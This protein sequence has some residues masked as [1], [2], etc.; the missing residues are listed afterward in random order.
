MAE[1]TREGDRKVKI[2]KKRVE[3]IVNHLRNEKEPDTLQRDK[4]PREEEGKDGNGKCLKEDKEEE[5]KTK[6]NWED[7]W[8]AARKRTSSLTKPPKNQPV[9]KNI[10][11]PK[12]KNTALKKKVEKSGKKETEMGQVSVKDYIR[13][14]EEETR[15][16]KL[17]GNPGEGAGGQ[18]GR[19]ENGRDGVAGEEGRARSIRA[20]ILDTE[21]RLE[22]QQFPAEKDCYGL[23]LELGR[24]LGGQN[25][26]RGRL[27][28]SEENGFM[29]PRE[30][31]GG[32]GGRNRDY[33]GRPDL[34]E[35]VKPEHLT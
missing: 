11:K 33:K 14:I 12:K 30:Q 24:K 5:N 25:P 17:A 1:Q 32:I 4:I 15:A 28:A 13:K 26:L 10:M 34:L 31:M 20:S 35:T 22:V 29:G 9:R 18:V 23:D 27:G 2:E 16:R 21:L 6:R 7:W 3:S 8:G 19:G